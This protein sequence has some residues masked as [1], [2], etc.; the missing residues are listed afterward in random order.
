MSSNP[1]IRKPGYWIYRTLWAAIDWVYPPVCGGCLRLGERWCTACQTQVTRL[2]GAICPVCG[3]PE[4]EGAVCASCQARPPGYTALRSWG[5]YTG[6]LREAI[7]QLKYKHDIGIAEALSRHLIELFCL[8]HWPVDI[9]TVVPLGPRRMQERGFNQS[10]LL[11]RPLGL[12]TG[13]SFQPGALVRIRE[14]PSQ[15]GLSARDRQENM[16]DAFLAAARVKGKQVLI[17]DDVA[18]T[19]ST[20]EACS[21]ALRNA[22]AASV[23]G[24]TL[25]RAVL[26]TAHISESAVRAGSAYPTIR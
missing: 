21:Q 1:G 9:L 15:V 18:T 19:G 23:Y 10:S 13:I 14:T 11:A 6:A 12:A 2:D 25:A 7:H 17:V 26:E 24:L 3:I 16:K 22:G 4:A 8:T 5:I 20:L